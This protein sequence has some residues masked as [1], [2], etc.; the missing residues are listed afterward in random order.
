[1]D[2]DQP[3][4]PSRQDTGEE[5]GEVAAVDTGPSSAAADV[6]TEDFVPYAEDSLTDAG[7]SGAVGRRR[8]K[9]PWLMTLF[10]LCL[11]VPSDLQFSVGPVALQAYRIYLLLVAPLL[12][13]KYLSPRVPKAPVCDIAMLLSPFWM[14]VTMLS[15]YDAPSVIEP[16]G[17]LALETVVAYFVARVS[18]TSR[19][20]VGAF[21]GLLVKIIMVLGPIGLVGAV[22]HRDPVDSVVRPLLGLPVINYD[23]RLGM[24]RMSLMFMHPIHWGIFASAGVGTA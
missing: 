5:H 22:L 11:L 19:A 18:F 2:E 24:Q 9:T 3:R 10:L 7:E 13:V 23:E 4:P 12:V 17:V 21:F 14:T 8:A 16:A 1:M 6:S 20:E 15:R